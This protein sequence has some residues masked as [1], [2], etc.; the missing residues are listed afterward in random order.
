MNI[1]IFIH[2]LSHEIVFVKMGVRASDTMTVYG[3]AIVAL[4][5]GGPL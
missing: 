5:L 3:H 1:F 4:K 2:I